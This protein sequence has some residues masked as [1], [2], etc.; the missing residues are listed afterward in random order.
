MGPD[1]PDRSSK[2]QWPEPTRVSTNAA[3]FNLLNSFHSSEV[4]HRRMGQSQGVDFGDGGAHEEE[5]QLGDELACTKRFCGG[6]IS[7]IKRKAPFYLSDFVDPFKS[8]SGALQCFATFIFLYFA[9]I[10]PIITFG[11]L[12]GTYC[13]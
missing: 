4:T 12:L 5:D 6:L 8:V 7:D 2:R 11:G 1:D 10:T 13:N 3:P 9:V